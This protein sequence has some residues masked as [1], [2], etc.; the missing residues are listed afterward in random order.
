MKE[1]KISKSVASILFAA[2]ELFW[3]YGLKKVSVEEI[4]EK[5]KVSKMTFYRNFSNKEELAI[6]VI[7]GLVQKSRTRFQEIADNDDL[8]FTD[9][10]EQI[11]LFKKEASNDMSVEI[12]Q[13]IFN[14]DFPALQAYLSKEQ[15]QSHLEL[16]KFLQ[17]AQEKGEIR[18]GLKIPFVMEML[19]IIQQKSMD[20]AFIQGLK[21]NPDLF[22][23][24]TSF[25][26]Y[27]I[28]KS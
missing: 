25:F 16:E 12:I 4:C 5:A 8:P 18:E 9:K 15:A 17:N 21:D 22:S 6:R 19:T 13:D 26:F 10:V 2:K 7:D 1:L 3:K 11:I 27:G 28:V 14:N 23:D 24:L 20:T